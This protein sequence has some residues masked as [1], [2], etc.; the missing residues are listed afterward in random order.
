MARYIERAS[1]DAPAAEAAERERVRAH[2]TRFFG[3]KPKAIRFP[4][5]ASDGCRTCCVELPMVFGRTV[6]VIFV[7]GFLA[8]FPP[9]KR[10]P[11]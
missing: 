8:G 5:K 6:E 11:Y 1:L 2:I 3:W 4:G 10:R 7:N 9:L